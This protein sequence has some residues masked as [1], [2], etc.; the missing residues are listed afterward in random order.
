LITKRR[1]SWVYRNSLP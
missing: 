1:N